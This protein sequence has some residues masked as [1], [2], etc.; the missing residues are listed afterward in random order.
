M[1][2]KPT[3]H[4]EEAIGKNIR[5]FRLA[6]GY[7]RVQLGALLNITHQ[8]IAKYENAENKVPVATLYKLTKILNVTVQSFFEHVENPE[9][10]FVE[11]RP[12]SET[13]RLNIIRMV[14][15]IK[16]LSALESIKGIIEHVV[17]EE[18]KYD[19]YRSYS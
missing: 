16:N 13:K 12:T 19:S 3:G 2:K 7:S 9:N 17:K 6:S 8:Q 11:I 18:E 14:Q 15:R 5:K 10:Y 1:V 4:I